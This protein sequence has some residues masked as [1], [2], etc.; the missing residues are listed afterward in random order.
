M[1]VVCLCVCAYQETSGSDGAVVGKTDI[2]DD[3]SMSEAAPSP[4][5]PPAM[6]LPAAGQ[7]CGIHTNGQLDVLWVDGSR[8]TTYPHQLYVVGDEVFQLIPSSLQPSCLDWTVVYCSGTGVDDIGDE[9]LQ[10]Q[11]YLLS[12]LLPLHILEL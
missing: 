1:H 3:G 2:T 9:V 8:S 6:S 4:P 7:I 10:S 12:I 11:P 5:V